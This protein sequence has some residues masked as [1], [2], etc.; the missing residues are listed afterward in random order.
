M[1]KVGQM[2]R[3]SGERISCKALAGNLISRLRTYYEQVSDPEIRQGS[4]A[5]RCLPFSECR[6]ELDVLPKALQRALIAQREGHDCSAI[7]DAVDGLRSV[8]R[9]EGFLKGAELMEERR[10]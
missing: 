8:H 2:R 6:E 10:R 3:K 1:K 9:V 4:F 5:A 7:S